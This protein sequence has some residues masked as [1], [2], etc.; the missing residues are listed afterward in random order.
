MSEGK[1]RYYAGLER[2][3]GAENSLLHHLRKDRWEMSKSPDSDIETLYM[4]MGMKAFAAFNNC[5]EFFSEF[6][7][8]QGVDPRT[9]EHAIR[10]SLERAISDA[11][12]ELRRDIS[13]MNDR[14]GKFEA[15]LNALDAGMKRIDR[16]TLDA[17]R[18]L[19]AVEQQVAQ[20]MQRAEHL[21]AS[22]AAESPNKRLSKERA[23]EL[24]LEAA[25]RLEEG[26][27]RLSLAAVAREANLKYGQMMYAFGNK[28]RFFKRY[29][30]YRTDAIQGGHGK[31]AASRKTSPA[32][33]SFDGMEEA[34]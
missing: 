32:K 19:A 30:E 1:Q 13:S 21:E 6:G 9:L 29:E 33:S 22:G 8:R 17:F 34:G 31:G 16:F 20:L 14:V 23:E 3:Q 11:F 28:E 4:E 5:L 10:S 15:V 2:Q 7:R 27:E 24:A 25:L 26:G 18:N 12:G